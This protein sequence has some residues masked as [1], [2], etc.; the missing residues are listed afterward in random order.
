MEK[1]EFRAKAGKCIVVLKD[2]FKKMLG[3]LHG[4]GNVDR[5]EA[6]EYARSF[7]KQRT[8]TSDC[9]FL[10]YDDTGRCVNLDQ[11]NC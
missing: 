11:F 3:V 7:N 6:M 4:I 9:I 1:Y 10:V 5:E 2:P 8:S